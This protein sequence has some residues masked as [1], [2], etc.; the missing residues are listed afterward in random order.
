MSSL[1]AKPAFQQ[2]IMQESSKLHVVPPVQLDLLELQNV[3]HTSRYRCSLS[4]LR[5][6]VHRGQFS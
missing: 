6:R 1:Y 3:K 5:I 2:P 4:S